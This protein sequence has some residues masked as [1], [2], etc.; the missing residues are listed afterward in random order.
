MSI[1]YTTKLLR[2]AHFALSRTK[3][4]VPIPPLIPFRRSIHSPSLWG[5][6]VADPRHRTT[7]SVLKAK[8]FFIWTPTTHELPFPF[9]LPQPRETG[10]IRLMRLRIAND[11]NETGVE[12]GGSRLPL[13]IRV[14][15]H[16]PRRIPFARG[17]RRSVVIRRCCLRHCS[18]SSPRLRPRAPRRRPPRPRPRPHH[19]RRPRP[20][21]CVLPSDH[22]GMLRDKGTDTRADN[23]LYM[24][25]LPPPPP[26]RVV[27]VVVV[28]SA[29]A[30]LSWTF[31]T[32]GRHS[33]RTTF[34][35][36]R[37]R[38]SRRSTASACA[39]CR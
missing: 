6:L 8:A 19:P 17:V 7:L 39:N 33:R 22:S 34:Q 38:S 26:L 32:L 1:P 10:T 3:L 24:L 18:I 35:P 25:P 9:D 29:V 14:S 37:R 23:L 31:V 20:L 12:G 15:G 5:S 13:R 16:P 11:D 4:T 21:K 36:I 2:C 30:L 27:V 28:M